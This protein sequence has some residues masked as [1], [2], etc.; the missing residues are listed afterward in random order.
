MTKREKMEYVQREG[1]RRTLQELA[2]ALQVTPERA[3]QI[4]VDAGVSRPF[5]TMTAALSEI[6]RLTEK[7]E[8]LQVNVVADSELSR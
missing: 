8:R 3:R 4:C 1:H 7:L 6:R 5:K 2:D